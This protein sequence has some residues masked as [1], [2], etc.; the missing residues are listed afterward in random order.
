MLIKIKF[1]PVAILFLAVLNL[2]LV[3]K[4]NHNDSLRFDPIN[5][6]YVNKIAS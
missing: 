6:S 1:Y 3:E 5:F 2:F 4:K